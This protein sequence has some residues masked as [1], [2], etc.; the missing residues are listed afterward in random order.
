MGFNKFTFSLILGYFC[1]SIGVSHL[2]LCVDLVSQAYI[3]SVKTG[4]RSIDLVV[5]SL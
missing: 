2:Q 3:G 5:T 1:T 4:N